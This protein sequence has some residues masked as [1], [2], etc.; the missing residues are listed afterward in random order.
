MLHVL[1]VAFERRPRGAVRVLLVVG[2][3]GPEL[4]ARHNASTAVDVAAN[5]IVLPAP[6]QSVAPR[7]DLDEA[8][9]HGPGESVA[10]PA[11]LVPWTP[12]TVLRPIAV[13]I[14]ITVAITVPFAG[15][16]SPAPLPRT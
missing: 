12:S 1:R 7:P 11:I 15:P 2:A 5:Q 3:A 14:A 16:S 6:G 13:A 10:P 9:C 4:V 8:R